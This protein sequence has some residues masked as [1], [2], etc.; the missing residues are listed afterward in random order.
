VRPKT[1]HSQDL[2]WGVLLACA[3]C[4]SLVLGKVLWACPTCSQQRIHLLRPV[5]AACFVPC[6][7]CR[8]LWGGVGVVPGQ[9]LRCEVFAVQPRNKDQL[10][11]YVDIALQD[12]L[13]ATLGPA[14]KRQK[15]PVEHR[16]AVTHAESHTQSHFPVAY[17]R[18]Q[19]ILQYTFLLERATS[20]VCSASMYS[21]LPFCSG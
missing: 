18:L 14:S 6:L 8:L 11:G 15:R 4:M 9:H 19:H 2:Q 5:L 7:L 20:L 13:D 16:Y 17:G 10:L 12:V 21:C 3:S 1:P